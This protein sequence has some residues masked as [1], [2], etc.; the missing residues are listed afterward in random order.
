MVPRGDVCVYHVEHKGF[1]Q[2]RRYN[3]TLRFGGI[4]FAI[5]LTSAQRWCK[6]QALPGHHAYGPPEKPTDFTGLSAECPQSGNSA[7]SEDV[8]QCNVWVPVGPP[9]S[10]GWPVWIYIHGGFLQ[11][12]SPNKE[13]PSDLLSETDVRCIVVAPTYRLNVFGFLA[14][15]ELK[16]EASSSGGSFGNFGFW[17]QRLAIEWTFENITGF[18][19]NQY[20]I[21]VG[22]LSAG[23]YSTF[24]Q[25]AHEIAL[26]DDQAI[27]RRVVLFS[28]GPG[29]PPKS[30]HEVQSHFDMLLAVLGIPHDIDAKSKLA[31]LRALPV[32]DL[33]VATTK[34]PENSFR[35]V[36]DGKWVRESL[37]HEIEDGRFAQV[38]LHRGVK[39]LIGDLP[40]E[41]N[42]YKKV[43]PPSSYESLV[44]RLA[45]EY[46]EVASR[47]L[48]K[49]YCP[50]GHPAEGSD[51]MET[52]GHIYADMQVH[53]TQRGLLAAISRTLPL[54]DILRY[55]INWRTKSVDNIGPPEMGVFHGSDLSIWFYGNRSGLPPDEQS[56][57]RK[58][59][60]PFAAFLKGEEYEYGTGSIDEARTIQPD[61]SIAIVKD[62]EW[63][64]CQRIW[65][66]LQ[67][68]RM[69][70]L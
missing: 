47:K 22:G 29:L 48:A 46:P 4:P 67:S 7:T 25:L 30:L 45:V 35:A 6:A 17:D 32:E 16:Q 24:H 41:N 37:F 39:I 12:G 60:E 53:V 58:F 70:R 18:G 33:V 11:W 20:N 13:D 69:S 28:N 44:R 50:G 15:H 56:T 49:L 9:P 26:P 27:I 23:A 55:R 38:M 3:N 63:Q 62:K 1:I 51:W 43:Q 8:L 10:G 61:M 59:L 40:D 52:F 66:S 64:R 19:G 31:R 57:I 2:G 42:V 14:S 65:Q 36:T 68:L 5:P 34:I 54:S 21:T